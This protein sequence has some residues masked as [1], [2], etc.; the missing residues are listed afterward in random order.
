MDAHKTTATPKRERLGQREVRILQLLADREAYGL[1][2]CERVPMSL[3]GIY[4]TLH[5]MEA[6]G[7]LVSWRVMGKKG[8]MRRYYRLVTCGAKTQ[9][10]TDQHC[11]KSAGYGTEHP[12]RG[13]CCD[14]GGSMSTWTQT[15]R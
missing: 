11:A 8:L 6:K 10:G 7:L 13:R 3:D 5:R 2:L 4:T 14:H 15:R 9:A 1:E 12:G